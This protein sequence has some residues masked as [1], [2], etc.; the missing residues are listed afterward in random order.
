MLAPT[1][2]DGTPAGGP[3]KIQPCR[4]VLD[5]QFLAEFGWGDPG[6]YMS[7]VVS[8]TG[9]GMSKEVRAR[10]F[11]PFFTTKPPGKGTGLGMAMVYGLVKQ[12]GGYVDV[13]SAP[14]EGTTVQIYFPITL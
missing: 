10:L 14:G 4:I 6:E 13:R 11:E 1:A 12:H 5:D 2:R 3:R 8:D 9:I 7:L